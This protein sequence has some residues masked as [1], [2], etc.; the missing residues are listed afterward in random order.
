M[1]LSVDDLSTDV[2][3]VIATPRL[4]LHPQVARHA[5]EMYAVL[6]DPAIYEFENA[7]PESI[8]WLRARFAKLESRRSADG[9]EHWLNWVIALRDGALIGFVQATVHRDRHAGIAYVLASR[10]WGQ[11]V[12]SE[13]TLAMIDELILRYQVREFTAV[14]KRAN[15]RSQK[16]LLRLG[17][18]EAPAS[19]AIRAA[20]EPDEIL[21]TRAASID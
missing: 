8:D 13:A 18:V 6:S 1:D 17:F 7:P 5:D 4:I 19:R 3:R 20:I 10:H 9:A 15:H 11:G 16:M 21:M 2:M 14:L 12:A